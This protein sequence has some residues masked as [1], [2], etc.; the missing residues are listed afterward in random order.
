MKNMVVVVSTVNTQFFTLPR[1][2]GDPV[3]CERQVGISYF[4]GLL[5]SCRR[6]KGHCV[7]KDVCVLGVGNR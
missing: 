4:V 6:T 7:Y 5:I 1:A 2:K 3:P